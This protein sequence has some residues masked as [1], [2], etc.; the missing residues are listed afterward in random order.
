MNNKNLN[1]MEEQTN[2]NDGTFVSVE[3]DQ[4]IV[5]FDVKFNGI[6]EI[7]EY[8]LKGVPK[9]GVYVGQDSKRY[10]CFDSSDYAYEDRNYW[11][12]VFS[13]SREELEK[14]MNTLRNMTNMGNYKKL[15]KELAPMLYWGGDD[16][17]KVEIVY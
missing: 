16:Y 10:P 15:T 9:D 8:A 2:A 1:Q 4:Q 17:Y 5:I 3:H 14:K 13:K 11:N 12:F 6:E 7:K